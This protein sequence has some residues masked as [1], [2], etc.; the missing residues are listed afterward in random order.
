MN[1]S[2]NHDLNLVRVSPAATISK[3]E[4][5]LAVT[6]ALVRAKAADAKTSERLRDIH[7]L[8]EGNE[9]TLQRMLNAMQPGTYIT[10]HHHMNP[11]KAESV[12]ILQGKLG[13]VA[14]DD[15][16]NPDWEQSVLV[17]PERGVFGVDCR[18]GLWHTF[19][20]IDPD[21][22]VFE[23]KPGPF[24][25]ATDKGFASWAPAEGDPKALP[26][27]A[28]LEDAFRERFDLPKRTWSA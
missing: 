20:A 25:P 17:D 14:F 27:L 8:H 11:A 15:D 22:V 13:F 23:A 10:P 16:G 24:D 9:D 7:V 18:A 12:I 3:H 6:D 1:D 21:T 2:P 19:I 28:Q 5:I 4:S 26:Y